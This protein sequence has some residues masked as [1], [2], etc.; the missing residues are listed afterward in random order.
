MTSEKEI[1]DGCKSYSRVAQNLL[2]KKYS[3]KMYGV[4]LRYLKNKQEAE[5]VL[6]DGFIK[7]FANIKKYSSSGSLEGWIRRVIVNVILDSILKKK[8]LRFDSLEANENDDSCKSDSLIADSTIEIEEGEYSK[9]ELDTALDQLPEGYRLVFNLFYLD[10]LSHSEI[11][12]LLSVD[13]GTSRTRLYRAK[14]ILKEYL[15]TIKDK[16]QNR[17]ARING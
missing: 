2:Y 15:I 16:K 14:K 12:T 11:A 8:K 13:E 5:D 4:C 3:A 6:H 17:E 10:E 9:K 7:V 1:I